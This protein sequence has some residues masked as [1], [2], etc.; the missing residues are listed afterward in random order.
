LPLA[1]LEAMAVGLPVVSTTVGG[2]P[3]LVDDGRSGV[4]VPPGDARAL[5]QALIA[6]LGDPARGRAM[7]AAGA[8]RVRAHITLEASHQAMVAHFRAAAAGHR[9]RRRGALP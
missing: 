1:I 7:G 3:E 9:R 4:L 2:I 5:A 6:V 8:E